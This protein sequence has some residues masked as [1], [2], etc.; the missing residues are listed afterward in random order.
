MSRLLIGSSNIRR[1]YTD[2]LSEHKYKMEAATVQRAFE[3]SMA[4]VKD[5]DRVIISVVENF[6]EKEITKVD[7]EHKMA[8]LT[9]TI[10]AFMSIVIDTSKRCPAT[11]FAL[12]VPTLRPA[13]Q[14]MTEM[15]DEIRGEFEKAYNK[16]GFLNITKIDAIARG[17]QLF[18]KDGVHFTKEAGRGFVSNLIEMAEVAFEAE[19]VDVAEDDS[20]IGKVV[21]AAKQSTSNMENSM[22]Q[23]LKKDSTEMK[24]WRKDLEL[25]L[26]ARF[27]ND[28]IMFARLREEADSEVNR[29][30][31]DR[32]LVMGL[33]EPTDL[34]KFGQERTEG[35]KKLAEDFC[36]KV[37]PN[38]DGKI[39]FA[40]V[41]GRPENGKIRIEFRLDTF[42]KA[43]EI[44]KMFAVNR[45]TNKLSQELAELHVTTVI[46]LGTRVRMEV[47]K[48]IAIKIESAT[49]V[50]YVPNFLPRPIMHIK[51]KTGAGE[52]GARGHVKT[53]TFVDTIIEYGNTVSKRDLTRAYDAAKGN[54]KGLMKQH[55]LVLDDQEAPPAAGTSAGSGKGQK[56][57]NPAGGGGR[58]KAGRY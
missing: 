27:H 12:A 15:E 50:A 37:K 11:K 22:L 46:T 6:I 56:R 3:V 34:P 52:T 5:G 49:E 9:E 19:S 25:K 33:T 21:T 32:T 44:R 48:A 31:E 26:N 36:K 38:F 53:L 16:D 8:A 28:N 40:A 14:W 4:S 55:F 54:F 13:N 41:M 2:S 57:P 10:D 1:F 39:L 29:R 17:S 43:R 30:K 35:V 58:G 20:L 7:E 24:K 18:E 47:M 45:T 51:K 42:E 23:D